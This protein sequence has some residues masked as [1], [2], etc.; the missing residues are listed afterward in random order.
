MCMLSSKSSMMVQQPGCRYLQPF[1]AYQQGHLS[2]QA[3]LEFEPMQEVRGFQAAD[4]YPFLLKDCEICWR[5]NRVSNMCPA[6]AFAGHCCE[7]S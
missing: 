6:T 7:D 2:W 3:A 5:L 1:H 4:L